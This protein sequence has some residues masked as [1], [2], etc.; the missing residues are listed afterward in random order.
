MLI[1][2]HAGYVGGIGCCWETHTTV[3]AWCR[4]ARISQ[5]CIWCS[6]TIGTDTTTQQGF[7]VVSGHTG[8]RAGGAARAVIE[9]DGGGGVL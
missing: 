4:K 7:L 6:G 8:E 2:A 3:R 9:T 5:R 1:R